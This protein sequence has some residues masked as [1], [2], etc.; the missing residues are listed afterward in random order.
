MPGQHGLHNEE[1]LASKTLIFKN[2]S[3]EFNHGLL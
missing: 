3:F 2:I 1:E